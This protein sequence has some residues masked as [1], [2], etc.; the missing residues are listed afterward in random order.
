[1]LIEALKRFT[2][3]E[4]FLILRDL[5]RPMDRLRHLLAQLMDL[6]NH[7]EST[8]YLTELSADNISELND[9]LALLFDRLIDPMIGTV[10]SSFHRTKAIHELFLHSDLRKNI[11]QIQVRSGYSKVLPGEE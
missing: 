7:K 6:Q 8:L 10:R 11:L 1:M 3:S 2:N 9:Q 4:D 5:F